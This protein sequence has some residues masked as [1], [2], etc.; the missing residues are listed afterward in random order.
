ML[1]PERVAAGVSVV[2]EVEH[3][4]ALMD[5]EHP[6]GRVSVPHQSLEAL[7]GPAHLEPCAVRGV[8]RGLL[9]PGT[10]P[11]RLGAALGRSPAPGER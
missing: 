2:V 3:V 7:I 8:G 6:V 11:P 1:I 10:R 5:I 4:T 9:A